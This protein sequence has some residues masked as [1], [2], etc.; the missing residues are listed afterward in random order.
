M[1]YWIYINTASRSQLYKLRVT[2]KL[3]QSVTGNDETLGKV[4]QYQENWAVNSRKGH[5]VY[6]PDTAEE[7]ARSRRATE[8]KIQ[9]GECYNT[10]EVVKQRLESNTTAQKPSGFQGRMKQEGK[11]SQLWDHL[12]NDSCK[13]NSRAVDVEATGDRSKTEATQ[14]SKTAV[15]RWIPTE[16]ELDFPRPAIAEAKTEIGHWESD[17]VIGVNHTG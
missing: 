15:S 6:L 12:S 8:G 14:R 1:S 11:L 16:W 2:D 13:T 9:K 4:Q 7:T 3:S 10:E 5:K 17:T